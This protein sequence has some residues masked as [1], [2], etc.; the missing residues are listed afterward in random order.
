MN[1]I[2]LLTIAGLLLLKWIYSHFR[3]RYRFWSERNVPYPEPRFPVG[4]VGET[5]GSKVHFAYIVEDLYRQLKHHG[6]YAGIFFFRDPVLL[7]LT[8]E[9]AKTV[10]VKDFNCFVDRGVYSNE[11]DDPL[12]ANLFFL[13]GHR[14]RQLRAKLTPTFT[15]GRL[16]AMFHTILT[17][18][19]QLDEFLIEYTKETGEV[20]VKELLARFTTDII[21]SC[22]FG[23]DCNSLVNPRSKFRE[24][25]KR[26]INFPKLK[27]LK[28]FFA[29]MFREAARK[30]RVRFN[31]ED[32]SNFFFEVV[33]DTIRYREEN[34][35][36]RKDFM[37]LLI[38][39]KNKGVIEVEG[40]TEETGADRLEKLTFEEIAAQAF[41]FFFA[42]FETSATTMTS[43]LY[44]LATHADVQEKGRRCVNDVLSKYGGE[45]SYEALMEMNYIDWIIQETLRLY[46]PVAS[47]HRITSKPYKLPNGSIIPDGTG[48]LI[49]NLAFQRDPEYFPEPLCFRPERFS[50]EEKER[51]HHFCHLPFGEG[52][53]NCIGMR[54][55]LLQSRMGI[56]LLLRNYRFATC[57]KTPIPLK[58]DPVALIQGPAGE[59]WLAIEKIHSSDRNWFSPKAS[60]VMWIYLL[61][62]A[63]S[64]AVWFVRKKYS[65]W[66]RLGVPY[67]KPRFPFG[68]LQAI[69][70]RVHSSQ[71]MTRFY[72]EMKGKYPFCG[73]YFFTNPVA[74]ALDLDFVKNVLVRDFQ[75]FHDRGM[76]Y[77]EKDDPISGHLFNIE[78]T[79]WTNLRKKLIPT[80]SSG[81]IKMMC[82]MII[83]VADRFRECIEKSVIDKSEV[84]M[85]DLLARFTTDV[86]GTCAF[87]I[88]CN[89]LNNPDAEFLRM[90]KKVFELPSGRLLKFFFM[91][92]FKEFAKKVHIK[93]TADDVS[94]FFF[95]V[96]R[97]T[98]EYREKNN[99]Q[100][101]DFMNLLIQLKQKGELDDSGENVGTLSLNEVVAQAFV[102][103]LGGFETSSTT[104]SYCLYELSLNEDVQEAARQCV[105]DAIVKHGGLNYEAIMD[106]EYIEQCINESLR[107]YPPGANLIRSVTK[108]Y[109]V[110]DSNVTF[111]KGMSVMIPVY[112]IHHDPEYYPDPE[113][114]DPDR[115]SAEESARRK[116]FTFI[117]FG[118]GPRICI[119]ARFGMLETKIGL[120]TLL[121][122]FRFSKCSKS[123]VPL[124]IS[125]RHAVL[126]PAGG[127]W[128]KV[129]KLKQ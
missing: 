59:V 83:T 117:P 37:Q 99:I 16:K 73:I 64:L 88:D 58:I 111:K 6:D 67:I 124:V 61:I 93:G 86:I 28:L 57:P 15:S 85:K 31:D 121:L 7:V 66:E 123:V 10:L 129:E 27:A 52:P 96:V 84:E 102:F 29:M 14:W 1:V 126:T 3:K 51:R 115:F 54:F 97:E 49:S 39:L 113:R 4:N 12:S 33:R 26:M 30:M 42:G 56:A 87:G 74:L 77:N 13:E 118:E 70:R 127:L 98:I 46:P 120:A 55:G 119:A 23:I 105:Q 36:R 72:R 5:L 112:A 41:V 81:K 128:L 91:A 122:N 89:S 82:P 94:S 50:E 90:G 65:H 19:Q 2:L 110:P 63:I 60:N 25:G 8:P 32:V 69:G 79:K 40:P 34:N 21:G 78:G 45:F 44:L 116:P 109:S 101:N 100:R 104:M 47:I 9:F 62:I 76:Y 11:R 38:D 80:F 107:K 75:Y 108:D 92:T 22:A 114:Y 71:L 17:V 53:R 18:G 103:F 68:N 35:V 48:V 95:K 20:E 43:V 106:M 125:P 24:M